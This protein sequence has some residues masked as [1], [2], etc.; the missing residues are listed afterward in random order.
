MAGSTDSAAQGPR[1]RTSRAACARSHIAPDAGPASS[2]YRRRARH[3]GSKED[4]MRTADPDILAF[5]A[6]LF[7]GLFFLL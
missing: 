7:G 2:P 3:P 6:L 5:A 1:L 4:T